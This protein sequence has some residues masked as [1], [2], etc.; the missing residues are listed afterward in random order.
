[1]PD[2]V[3][4]MGKGTAHYCNICDSCHVSHRREYFDHRKDVLFCRFFRWFRLPISLISCS[5][6]RKSHSRDSGSENELRT[7]RNTNTHTSQPKTKQWQQQQQ[8]QKETNPHTSI[9]TIVCLAARWIK[10]TKLTHLLTHTNCNIQDDVVHSLAVNS[11]E[12]F[13]LRTLALIFPSSC[14]LCVSYVS[15]LRFVFDH[16]DIRIFIPLCCFASLPSSL[17]RALCVVTAFGHY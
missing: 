5:I 16:R 10:D 17:N 1:M 6:F 3:I 2:L 4:T 7:K 15:A 14:S 11:L 8:Q 13:G 12:L 9:S